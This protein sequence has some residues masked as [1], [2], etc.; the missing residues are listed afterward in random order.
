M[1]SEAERTRL[2]AELCTGP[3]RMCMA[4]GGMDRKLNGACLLEGPQLYLEHGLHVEVRR[5]W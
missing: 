3:G 5:V 2:L 1:L 4:L